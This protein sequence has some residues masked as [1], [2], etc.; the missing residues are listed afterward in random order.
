MTIRKIFEFATKPVQL[1]LSSS[2][3]L[4]FMIT[5]I[6][7]IQIIHIQY[8]TVTKVYSYVKKVL[9]DLRQNFPVAQV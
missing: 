2:I 6:W 1:G 3:C 8:I 7:Y 5:Q 4:E 9:N